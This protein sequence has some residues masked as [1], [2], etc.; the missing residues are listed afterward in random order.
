MRVGFMDARLAAKKEKERNQTL[1][2]RHSLHSLS[3]RQRDGQQARQNGMYSPLFPNSN[4]SSHTCLL[5]YIWCCAWETDAGEL[6]SPASLADVSGKGVRVSERTVRT[7]SMT[8]STHTNR[9]G[10]Q[11]C[12]VVYYKRL[13]SLKRTKQPAKS[14]SSS[15]ATAIEPLKL[16]YDLC[17]WLR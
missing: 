5:T 15:S 1:E 9:P 7:T 3:Y 13:L 17:L 8:N 4:R 14:S 6:P 10:D 16:C 11:L 2:G 12:E